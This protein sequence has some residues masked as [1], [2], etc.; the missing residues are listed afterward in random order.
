MFL[1]LPFIT[2]PEHLGE[3]AR[4]DVAE[5]FGTQTCGWHEEGA[6][7]KMSECEGIFKGNALVVK[8]AMWEVGEVGDRRVV[9]ERVETCLGFVEGIEG[10]VERVWYPRILVWRVRRVIPFQFGVLGRV[11]CIRKT[12]S[13]RP[14]DYAQ[15]DR[16]SS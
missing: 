14:R 1:S 6:V 11:D 13:A 15:T 8:A 9:T 2:E 5:C 7:K 12:A 16:T 10:D 4:A 3:R